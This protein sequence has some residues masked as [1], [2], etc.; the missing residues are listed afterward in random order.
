MLIHRKVV[1]L[2]TTTKEI[3]K[4]IRTKQKL[5]NSNNCRL[6][7]FPFL[8]TVTP[9]YWQTF[10]K[11]SLPQ[12]NIEDQ[13]RYLHQLTR[14]VVKNLVARHLGTFKAFQLKATTCLQKN[15]LQ[16][17]LSAKTRL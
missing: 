11:K 1:T 15:K 12:L 3:S 8:K 17:F 13:R 5:E 16:L 7:L 6:A 14:A 4:P 10:V 2:T 9:S